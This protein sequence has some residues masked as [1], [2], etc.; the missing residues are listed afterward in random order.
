VVKILITQMIQDGLARVVPSQHGRHRIVI[1]PKRSLY[2]ARLLQWVERFESYRQANLG[3]RRCQG[4]V[5]GLSDPKRN[6]R[7][8][9]KNVRSMRA[10]ARAWRS[11]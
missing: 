7:S 8:W 11:S 4:A 10:S 9:A 1:D 5:V 2:Q 3:V 6:V